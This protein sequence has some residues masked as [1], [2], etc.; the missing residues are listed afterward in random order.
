MTGDTWLGLAGAAAS[1]KT[2]F[3]LA[4]VDDLVASGHRVLVFSQSRLMLDILAAG[5]RRPYLRIDGSVTSAEERQ[6]SATPIRD[7]LSSWS[8]GFDMTATRA[9][10]LLVNAQAGKPV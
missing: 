6:A 1:C 3:V 10:V 5:L 7:P 8:W 2:H 4:L 9:P